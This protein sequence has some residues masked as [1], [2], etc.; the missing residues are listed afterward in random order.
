MVAAAAT[1]RY[2]ARGLGHLCHGPG[3]YA[4]VVLGPGEPLPHAVLLPVCIAGLCAG[5]VAVRPVP[6]GLADPAVRRADSAVPAAVPAHLLLLPQG[7]L[8]QLLAVAA[9]LRGGRA[10]R[11]LHR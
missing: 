7:L 2:R 4:E 11:P 8:P 1:D 3:L 5:V 9:G 6:A 10:A